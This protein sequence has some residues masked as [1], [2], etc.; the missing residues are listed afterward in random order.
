MFCARAQNL[1]EGVAG[2]HL[3]T[4]IVVFAARCYAEARPVSSYVIRSCENE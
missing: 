1:L 4:V 2:L 3:V